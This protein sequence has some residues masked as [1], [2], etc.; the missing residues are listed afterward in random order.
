M[1]GKWKG[2]AVAVLAGWTVSAAAADADAGTASGADEKDREL[3][4]VTVSA[5]ADGPYTVR[6]TASATKLDLSL[7]ETPQSE[8]IITRQ[9]LDDQN[10][11]TLRQVLDVTP[12]VYSYAYDTERVVFTS[13]GF[14]IDSLLYDGMPAVSSFDTSSIDDSLDTALYE[15]IEVVRGATG[16]MTG[17][18]SPAASINLIR[19][20]ADSDHFQ[21]ELD[22]TVGSWS[23]HRIEGD[24]QSPLTSDGRVRGRLVAVYEDHESYQNLYRNK[25]KIAYGILDA[26]LT[27][28]TR[29][30]V[31]FDYQDN[32]PTGNTWG[33]FPLFFADG[34]QTNWPRWVTTAADWSF[35]DRR[36]K[37]VFTELQQSLAGDWQLHA[38][39]TWRHY[40]EDLALLYMFGYPDSQTGEGL[41]PF[42]YKSNMKVTDRSA[43]LFAKGPFALFGR[44]HELVFGY[45]G[46]RVYHHAEYFPHRDDLPDPGNFFNWDGSYPRPRFSDGSQLVNDIHSRQDAGYVVARLSLADPLKLIAGVRYASWKTDYFVDG[47]SPPEGFHYSF[48]EAIPYAG[49][50]YDV[51]PDY[52]LFTSY[53]TIFKPQNNRDVTGRYLDPIDGRSF[54]AGIKGEH[55]GGR[56]NTALT[57]FE[58]RQ[59][60][61]ATG[62]LDPET[63]NPV[64]LADG[65]Q[66]SIAIDG[67]RTRGFEAEV[68]GILLPGWNASLGWSHYLFHDSDGRPVRTFVPSTLVRTFTTWN[69]PGVLNR[70]T[71][72]GGINWQS[73]SHTTVGTPDGTAELRQAGVPLLNLM[74]R[75]QV[76]DNVSVQLNANNLLDRKY[77]VLDEFDNTYYGP[78]L[79]WAVAVSVKF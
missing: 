78:P 35:W 46:S 34:T 31:G 39:V 20:H 57:V 24:M 59:N 43:D 49:L 72:G 48:N 73:T 55:F 61:V 47:E 56:L 66:A 10:L 33:S 62:L 37:T 8:T 21:V 14:T 19:K 79:S 6:E 64:L 12:G 77:Y 27:D 53:T 2:W 42:A 5:D 60:N 52:S 75:Y 9:E 26:D 30:S 25:R 41:V 13:R 76:T 17:A 3:E 15:R 54:E 68:Q 67:V 51:T 44:A 50:I 69:P 23:D 28:T 32:H 58:T 1:M 63:G 70:L 4:K 40:D 45:N 29:V 74:G 16:L 22:G 18:G 7:R 36:T 11:T 65:T 38:T 71:I